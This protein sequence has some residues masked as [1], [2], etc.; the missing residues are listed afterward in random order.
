[1][2]LPETV[3][4]RFLPAPPPYMETPE[5]Q[6]PLLSQ[7]HRVEWAPDKHLPMEW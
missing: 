3:L 7:L 6:G 1:M 2:S 5:G 4:A